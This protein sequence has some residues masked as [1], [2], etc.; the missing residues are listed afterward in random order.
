MD[1]RA[2]LGYQDKTRQ[3]RKQG[4]M[5]ERRTNAERMARVGGVGKK[6]MLLIAGVVVHWRM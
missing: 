2:V 3:V 4:R 5:A 1:V 6:A